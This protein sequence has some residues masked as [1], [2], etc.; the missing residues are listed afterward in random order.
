MHVKLQTVCVHPDWIQVKRGTESG[1]FRHICDSSSIWSGSCCRVECLDRENNS[2][3]SI[4][5]SSNTVSRFQSRHTL[6]RREIATATSHDRSQERR[7]NLASGTRKSSVPTR[8]LQ[9]H[10]WSCS[11][12][13]PATFSRRRRHA[14]SEARLATAS[15]NHHADRL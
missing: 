1:R 8:F 11:A 9:R 7:K 12:L 3:S 2:L 5:A 13:T 6:E 10:F 15:T 14:T 4:C